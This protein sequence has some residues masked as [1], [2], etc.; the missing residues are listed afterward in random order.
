MKITIYK[1]SGDQRI[2]TE[3]GTTHSIYNHIAYL[4]FI[5]IYC[6]TRNR[7]LIM[8]F[9]CGTDKNN[10]EISTLFLFLLYY[11]TIMYLQLHY[12]PSLK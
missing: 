7:T 10:F 6:D 3:N 2:V 12:Y 1:A 11:E 5:L 4:G 9:F 8:Q